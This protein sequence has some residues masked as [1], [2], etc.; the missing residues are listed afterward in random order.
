[1]A[2]YSTCHQT[3]LI[4]KQDNISLRHIF[5]GGLEMNSMNH[6]VAS[7]Q[8][9]HACTHRHTHMTGFLQSLF[10]WNPFTFG[11]SNVITEDIQNVMQWE[12]F[13]PHDWEGN[14]STSPSHPHLPSL[15][16]SKPSYWNEYWLCFKVLMCI[17]FT[18]FK[19]L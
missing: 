3:W 5:H 14:F 15:L 10:L 4:S 17:H 7:R 6:H 16:I 1:M 8:Y 19:K 2:R 18:F 12:N 11:W 9:T 13:R